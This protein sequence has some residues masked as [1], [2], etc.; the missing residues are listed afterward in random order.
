MLLVVFSHYIEFLPSIQHK[1]IGG[2][3][4]TGK[5]RGK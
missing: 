3:E 2:Q 5:T 1:R 4:N